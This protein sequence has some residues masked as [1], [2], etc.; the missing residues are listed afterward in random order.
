MQGFTIRLRG[1][2]FNARIGVFPQERAVG[3]DFEVNVELRL[4]AS[5]FES[6]NLDTSISYADVYRI[7]ERRMSV[8]WRLLES[9]AKAI[10]DEIAETYPQTLCVRV[11]IAKLALPIAGIQGDAEVEYT[12]ER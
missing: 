7:V 11:A 12:R 2:R 1:L 9:V 5:G 3:N 6:E 8:E 10:G 4:D